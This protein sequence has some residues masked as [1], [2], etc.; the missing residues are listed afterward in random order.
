MTRPALAV[1]VGLILGVATAALDRMTKPYPRTCRRPVMR[2][3][4]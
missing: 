4:P 3:A 2:V 1:L